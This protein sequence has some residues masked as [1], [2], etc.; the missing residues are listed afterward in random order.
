[1]TNEDTQFVNSWWGQVKALV[2]QPAPDTGDRGVTQVSSSRCHAD[3]ES[4]LARE[5]LARIAEDARLMSEYWD[6]QD[7]AARADDEPAKLPRNG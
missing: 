7:E 3:T 5:E 2:L 6:E 4:S 1:M